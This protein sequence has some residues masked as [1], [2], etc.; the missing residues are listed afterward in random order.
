MPEDE[1]I[2]LRD[3]IV[4]EIQGMDEMPN[5]RFVFDLDYEK[6]LKVGDSPLVINPSWQKVYDEGISDGMHFM[7]KNARIAK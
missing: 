2:A 7:P 4:D 5:P 6:E 1:T 3:R